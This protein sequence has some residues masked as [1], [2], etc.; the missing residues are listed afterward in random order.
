MSVGRCFRVAF[1]L[2][3]F[4]SHTSSARLGWGASSFLASI[5]CL[6]LSLLAARVGLSWS[7]SFE[8]ERAVVGV[9]PRVVREFEGMP[10]VCAVEAACEA[11]VEAIDDDEFLGRAV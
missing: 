8:A 3:F 4:A 9:P 6:R 1:F 5:F 10:L 7:T 11:V 2:S